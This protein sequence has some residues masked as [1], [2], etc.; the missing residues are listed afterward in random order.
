MKIR[1]KLEK[2][3]DETLRYMIRYLRQHN[4]ITED[5]DGAFIFTGITS[6]KQLRLLRA[7]TPIR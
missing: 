4:A 7:S 1:D 5:V 6:K 2:T 3:D